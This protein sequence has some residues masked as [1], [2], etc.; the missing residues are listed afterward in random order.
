MKKYKSR[1][2]KVKLLAGD[3][4]IFLQTKEGY[5]HPFFRTFSD[6]IRLNRDAEYKFCMRRMR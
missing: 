1:T 3:W 5:K 4:E 6:R 2:H